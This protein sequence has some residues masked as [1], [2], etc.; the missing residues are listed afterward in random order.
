MLVA[1]G[2]PLVH[3]ARRRRRLRAAREPRA[4]ILATYDVFADRAAELGWPRAPGETP[5]EYRGRLRAVEGLGMEDQ[6]R[7]TRMTQTVVRAAYAPGEPGADVSHRT[8]DDAREVLHALRD[9]ASWKQ[10]LLG[11]YRRD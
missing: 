7:L 4:L 8:A 11:L 9:T 5:E 1:I 3:A 6:E 10:R 2:I